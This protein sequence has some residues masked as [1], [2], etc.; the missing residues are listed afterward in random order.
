M[1]IKIFYFTFTTFIFAIIFTFI[2]YSFDRICEYPDG[3]AMMRILREASVHILANRRRIKD[4]RRVSN[5]NPVFPW[6]SIYAQC[7]RFVKRRTW[8]RYFYKQNDEMSEKHLR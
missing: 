1:Q 6:T 2:F 4:E 7:P 5:E 8:A 3:Q